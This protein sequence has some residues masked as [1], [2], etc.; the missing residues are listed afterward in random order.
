MNKKSFKYVFLNYCFILCLVGNAQNILIDPFIEGGFEQQGGLLGN[1]WSV[2]NSNINAW[3]SGNVA[4]ANSGNNSVFISNTSGNSFGYDISLYQTSHFYRDVT[5]PS[6][7]SIINLRFNY[8]SLGEEFFDRLMVYWAPISVTPSVNIPASSDTLFPGANLLFKANSN[9][10]TYQSVNLLLPSTLAGKSFRLIFTWQNDDSGGDSNSSISIDDIYLASS[11][12]VALNG[13]YTIDNTIPTSLGPPNTGRNFNNFSDAVNYL[14]F[15]GVSG[16]IIFEVMANQ[17]FLEKPQIIT[18]SGSATNTI[19]FQKTGIGLNPKFIGKEGVG[20]IDACFTLKGADY[21]TF[22]GIDLDTYNGSVTSN[23][24]MEFGYFITNQN[25]SNGA[26]YNVIKNCKISLDRANNCIAVYQDV[27]ASSPSSSSGSNSFN[28]YDNITIENSFQGIFLKGNSI[29]KDESCEVSYC[30]VGGLTLFDIGGGNNSY[31]CSGI[32]AINQKKLKVNNNEIKNVSTNNTVNGIFLDEIS[33]NSEIFSNKISSIVNNGVLSIAPST[34][35]RAN[36]SPI[37]TNVLRIYNNCISDIKSSYTG[38]ITSDRILKGI[39]VQTS[40]GGDPSSLIEITHNTVKIDG[41]QSINCSSTCFETGTESGPLIKVRNNIFCNYTSAQSSIARHYCWVSSSSGVLG[42]TG[43]VSDF[44][45]FYIADYTNGAIGSGG[46]S[47]SDLIT[48]S[49]WKVYLSQ[50]IHSRN[51]NPVFSSGD[52]FCPLHPDLNSS[53]ASMSLTPYILTDINGKMRT[54]P[55][56]DIGACEFTPFLFD[57]K[58][59]NIIKPTPEK[60]YN[61]IETVILEIKNNSGYDLDFFSHPVDISI[62]V[63]G[64]STQTLSVLLNSNSFNNNSPLQAFKTMSVTVGKLDMSAHGSYSFVCSTFFNQDQNTA[65]DTLYDLIRINESPASLPQQINF[66]DFSGINL[67]VLFSGWSEMQGINSVPYNNE[68]TW[69]SGNLFGQ[70]AKV[71]MNSNIK[72]EWIVSPKIKVNSKTMLSYKAAITKVGNNSPTSMGVDDQLNLLISSDCGKSFQILNTLNYSSGLSNVW[73]QF[74]YSLNNYAGQEI[75]IAFQAKEGLIINNYDLH[76]D[77]IILTNNPVYDLSVNNL[78]DLSTK[79]CY[80]NQEHFIVTLKNQGPTDIDFSTENVTL[81]GSIKGTSTYTYSLII[82]SGILLKETSQNYTISSSI[83]LEKKGRYDIVS[84][85]S[86]PSQ[87]INPTND[88]LKQTIYSQNPQVFFANPTY[89]LCFQDSIQMIPTVQINGVSDEN[90]TSIKNTEGP[91][92]IPDNSLMGLK[93][94]INID[95]VEGYAS[96]LVA[97]IIDSLIHTY[98]GDLMISLIAPDESSIKLSSNNG[99]MG[100]NY[101]NTVFVNNTGSSISNGVAP[102]SGVYNPEQSFNLL[103]GLA[104]GLWKL[105]IKDV[106]EQ[107][108]GTLYK[109]SLVFKRANSLSSF[110]WTP[111]THLSSLTNLYPKVSPIVT[112]NYTISISD[113]KGCFASSDQM[114]NVIPLPTISLGN[115]T[116]I[117]IGNMLILNAGSGF[118]SYVWNN[119]SSTEQYTV[120][121]Q[122]KYYIEV[123]NSNGCSGSD[124]IQVEISQKPNLTISAPS[125]SLCN[126]VQPFTF[127]TTPIGGIFK[128]NGVNSFGIFNPKLVST[129]KNTIYYSFQDKGQCFSKDSISLDLDILATPSVSLDLVTDFICV[130]SGTLTLMGGWPDGGYY[131][132]NGVISGN[133]YDSSLPSSGTHTLSYCYTNQNGCSNTAQDTLLLDVCSFI[134]SNQQ[135]QITIYPNPT[136]DNVYLKNLPCNVAVSLYDVSG[137]LLVSDQNK[138]STFMEIDLSN[139]SSGFYYIQIQNSEKQITT[140]KIIK[141]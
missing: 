60:C 54:T 6:G 90:K 106:S 127:T 36:L 48:I 91:L 7:H 131:L 120:N 122:G 52:S 39:Y 112:S 129:G 76:L 1:G 61:T 138:L 43:S 128:G 117:C 85:A 33:G 135:T 140:F 115:D 113:S 26:H 38:N 96:Q 80:N 119:G 100:N 97:V 56:S 41:S 125:Y 21:I 139:F 42:P 114:V 64:T 69:T 75:I 93:S 92:Q 101:I 84:F 83:D 46:A 24:K 134:Y 59:T 34:G 28:K 137:K 132:G 19:L 81:F 116:S 57:I 78:F 99:A 107:E 37:G 102:F 79:A 63:Y 31:T 23:Q 8:K 58:P 4:G 95:N 126:N 121:A 20:S 68:S 105:S 27:Y 109:W 14:N 10:S 11:S 73:K 72:N 103:S 53:A 51:V 74:F 50:D 66:N 32:S 82:N 111:N 86:I 98:D 118:N 62:V 44:N 124:T 133:L 49:D 16:P 123:T 45:D 65:N 15:N 87:D 88:T 71:T 94:V 136:S 3:F 9:I 77:D 17:I 35:I 67:H 108:V 5:I 29:F 12:P 47:G 13:I 70:D 104:N 22:N 40:S 141:K 25:S 18:T 55:N 130:N 30:K 110:T 89:T 2:E